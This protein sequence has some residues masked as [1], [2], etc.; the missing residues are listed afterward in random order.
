MGRQVRTRTIFDREYPCKVGDVRA[1][2]DLPEPFEGR[3][4]RIDAPQGR[5]VI[6]WD[7]EWLVTDL[8]T[9]DQ[10]KIKECYLGFRTY[11]EMEVIAWAAR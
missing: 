6:G 3:L 9:S 5:V 11:T 1:L 7:R 8:L 10:I 4:V 2:I